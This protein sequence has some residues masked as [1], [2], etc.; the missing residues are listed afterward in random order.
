MPTPP[1]LAIRREA[2]DEGRIKTTLG[3]ATAKG[4]PLASTL[5]VGRPR[6]GE[7]SGDDFG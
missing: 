2:V 3:T 1:P 5:M 6:F 4:A 7:A